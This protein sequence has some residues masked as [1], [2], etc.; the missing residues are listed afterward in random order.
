MALGAR[1][2]DILRL[3]VGHGLALTLAGIAIGLAGS[4]ALTRVLASLLYRTSAT[5]PFTFAFSAG[6]FL[7][8]AA[9][10]SYVPAR[11]AARIDPAETLH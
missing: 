11:R 6:I 3:V 2:G 9:A 10:A 5:D 4:V 8:V 1:Q 7:A